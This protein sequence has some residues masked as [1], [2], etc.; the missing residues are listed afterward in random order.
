MLPVKASL[1]TPDPNASA[2]QEACNAPWDVS[3]PPLVGGRMVDRPNR[4]LLRVDVGGRQVSAASADPGRLEKILVPGV[5]VLLA[6]AGPGPRRTA[7]TVTLAREGRVWVCLRPALACQIVQSAVARRAVREFRGAR[8]AAREVRRGASRLDF[9]LHHRGHPW[10]VEVKAC[11]MV[12]GR[13][14]LFPDAPTVRGRRHLEE[15]IA[16][17]RRGERSALLFV[18]HRPDADAVSPYDA[19]DPAFGAALRRARRA[20][21]RLLAY[22]CAVTPRGM[23]LERPIPVIA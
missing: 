3:F 12:E 21:V 13:R 5:D 20:G 22:A 17:R 23:R 14:A 15:L 10:L 2:L 18:V 11:A 7:Y 4:F 9:V 16:A 19:I 6:A 1:Q 8:V